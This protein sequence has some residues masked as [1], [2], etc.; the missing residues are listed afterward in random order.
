MRKQPLAKPPRKNTNPTKSTILTNT[1]ASHKNSKGTATNTIKDT[2]NTSKPIRTKSVLKSK[3][4]YENFIKKSVKFLQ[5]EAKKRGVENF[6]VGLSGGIDSAVVAYLCKMATKKQKT[7]KYPKN[8]KLSSGAFGEVFTLALPS[9][10]SSE[11]SLEHAKELAA[12]FD[13]PLEILPL[14]DYQNAFLQTRT[15]SATKGNIQK[16]PLPLEMGNFC[17]RIR[18]A[19]L[20]D[21]SA[22]KKAIV[23]GT[24]NKSEL[25]LGYGTIFGDLACAINPI[26]SLYKSEIFALAKILK[27]PDS[28]ISK[29]PSAELYAGQS[30]EAELGFSYDKIDIVL[31]AICEKYGD[32][33]KVKNFQKIDI[34][35]LCD[36]NPKDIAKMVKNRI[37]QNLFKRTLPKIFVP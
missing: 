20:Y 27:I 31:E 6:V 7:L 1:H 22:Q 30:D 8:T 36:K 19:L 10:S 23:I 28:I 13:L 4:Y 11:K 16:K 17:A 3:K 34:K 26:G 29:P 25:M 32:F 33:R 37:T 14:E 18:M 24:S 12:K 2:T 15:N 35:R 5:K 9:L 21:Y